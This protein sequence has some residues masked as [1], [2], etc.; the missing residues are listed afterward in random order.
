M[1]PLAVLLLVLLM[2]DPPFVRAESAFMRHDLAG[3]ER[4]YREVLAADTVARHRIQAAV[5]LA[6]IAWR[7]RRDTTG[8]NRWLQRAPGRRGS[9][10]ANRERVRMRLVHGDL[11]GAR[12]AA[13]RAVDAAASSVDRDEAAALA[14]RVAIEPPLAARLD[15]MAPRFVPAMDSSLVAATVRLAEL[16]ERS[17][18]ALEPARLLL[19]G[20]VLTEN[21]AAALTAWHS[22]YLVT[23]S[24]SLTGP[25]A[26]P[27]RVLDS[28][29]PRLR[30]GRG[31]RDER[32]GIVRALAGSR[33]FAPAAA[34]AL[35][36]VPDGDGSPPA[37]TDQGAREVVAYARFLLDVERT[38]DEYYRETMLGRGAPDA[39]RKALVHRG[40]RLWPR[41][42]WD[43]PPPTFTPPA[44]LGELSRRFG[45]VVTLGETAGYQDMHYGHRVVDERRTVR[46]YGREAAVRFVALDAL[47]S[48]GFQSWA[49]NGRAAHGGWANAEM[50]VQIRPMYAEHPRRVWQA[51]H[52]TTEQRESAT[53]IAADSAADQ[54]RA[55]STPVAYFPGVAA[56]LER[57][58]RRSLLDTLAAAGLN[59]TGLEAAFTRELGEATVESS[60]FAHEGRHAIDA[61]LPELSSEDRE[62]RAKLSQVTFAPHPRLA[63]GSILDA[64]VGDQTPHGQANRRVLE[65]VRGWMASLAAEIAGLDRAAPLLPQLPLLT[66]AQLRSAFSSLDP[67]AR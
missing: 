61:A 15:P 8:A 4:G 21:G 44:L 67:F 7:V 3:A 9:F 24:D 39:W 13:E 59:G 58:G 35:A 63:L 17:P 28:L 64:T 23:T 40:A 25:L 41:L 12:V 36:P 52:D 65:G 57:D 18:G 66:D 55:R 10:A 43:G 29:L 31:T 14:G 60:I 37:E 47:V 19:A 2:P 26:E 22:Y 20:A 56:R 38:T 6:N 49:W 51:L 42:A 50:I 32:L 48:N 30:P 54:A 5:T 46:Q 45:A 33:A 53:R 16:V 62:F 27:R 11:A 34:L 1:T